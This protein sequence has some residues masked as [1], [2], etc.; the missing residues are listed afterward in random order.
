MRSSRDDDSQGVHVLECHARRIWNTL[1]RQSLFGRE[2]TQEGGP[3][4]PIVLPRLGHYV[5]QTM[6]HEPGRGRTLRSARDGAG[7]QSSDVSRS[8]DIDKTV[9]LHSSGSWPS[10]AAMQIDLSVCD[11][12]PRIRQSC[13]LQRRKL[14]RCTIDRTACGRFWPLTPCAQPS[15]FRLL[16]RWLMC[17]EASASRPHRISDEGGGAFISAFTRA[18]VARSRTHS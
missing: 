5:A 17:W 1:I 9:A 18:W 2:A 16:R 7:L 11:T 14:L 3:V 8:F 15:A 12:L 10:T 6:P 13:S 4:V